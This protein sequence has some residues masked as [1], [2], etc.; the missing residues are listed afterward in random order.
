MSDFVTK[1][2][3]GSV[4]LPN[5]SSG[6]MA[7]AASVARAVVQGNSGNVFELS[8]NPEQYTRNFTVQY[9]SPPEMGPSRNQAHSQ[10]NRVTPEVLEIKFTI[11]GTGVV[12]VQSANQNVLFEGGSSALNYV[13]DKLTHLKTVVYGIQDE[14]H[15]PPFMVVN[16]GKLVFMGVLQGMTQSFTLFNPSG[17]PLRVEVSLRIQEFKMPNDVAAALSLL[18]PD[19]TK[20]RAVK[21]SDTILTLTQSIYDKTDYYL[22]VAKINELTNFRRLKT[23]TELLFPPIV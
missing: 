10:F 17:L 15:R 22:E 12:P 13:T 3:I 5:Q 6:A 4:Q 16:W 19:L 8:I 1:L 2:R 9:V 21:S 20:R 18:S 14:S 11:D 7:K 23:N